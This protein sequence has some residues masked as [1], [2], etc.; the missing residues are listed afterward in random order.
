MAPGI[1][2]TIIFT[3]TIGL[4]GL[5]FVIEKKEGLMDRSWVAGVNSIEILAAHIAS[6]LVIMTVQ[7]TLLI[8]IANFVFNVNLKG[9]I[10][11][12]ALLL[13]FQGFCGMSYGTKK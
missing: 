10:I 4:T 2:A 3:L 1:M 5:M 13:L 6:K 9:P 11:I 12:S 8:L 7:I